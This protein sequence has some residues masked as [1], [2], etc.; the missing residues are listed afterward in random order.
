MIPGNG[1]SPGKIARVDEND[2]NKTD[3]LNGSV[4]YLPLDEE[5]KNKLE[6]GAG[7][8]SFVNGR[9]LAS[10]PKGKMLLPTNGSNLLFNR[11]TV[12]RPQCARCMASRTGEALVNYKT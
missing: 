3:I 2:E 10:M 8:L 4:P 7:D 12:Y 6:A 1:H 9:Y 11:T 5:Y